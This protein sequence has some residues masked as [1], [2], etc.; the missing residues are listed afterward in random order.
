M[1]APFVSGVIALLL[2]ANPA[3]TPFQVRDILR[4]TATM[5]AGH[6]YADYGYAMG[7]GV[8]D[9]AEAIAVALR[10][11]DG[12]TLADA[13]NNASFNF[14]STPARSTWIRDRIEQ[15]I[16]LLPGL[17]PTITATGHM[18][19]GGALTP[20]ASRRAR[21]PSSPGEPVQL[22]ARTIH[23]NS[24]SVPLTAGGFTVSFTISKTTP[25]LPVRSPERS[26]P[27]PPTGRPPTTGP[28]PSASAARTPHRRDRRGLVE[29]PPVQLRLH[30]CAIARLRRMG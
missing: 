1:A 24:P 14:T 20:S 10:M 6:T 30:R 26:P 11:R 18:Y 7:T 2:E 13:L 12:D 27:T 8:V 28:C 9:A 21:R 15:F 4:A 16:P 22:A 17:P 19:I 29:L 23:S 3:L 25:S 5:T